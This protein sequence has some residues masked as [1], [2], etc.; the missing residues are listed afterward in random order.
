MFL[1][2]LELE[3]VRSIEHLDLSFDGESETRQWTLVLGENGTGKST[4]LK[5]IAL[6]LAGSDSLSEL[7][8]NTDDWIRR[9]T[10]SARI[11]VELET[12]DGDERA[13]ELVLHRGA[14][15][16][17]V[18]DENRETLA[19]LDA[20][21][22]QPS[23]RNYY[24][25]GYGVT[26]RQAS[27][28]G[29]SQTRS[30]YSSPRSRAVATLFSPDTN[31][32]DLEGW[33]MDLDYRRDGGFEIAQNALNDL[34]PGVTLV[35]IDRKR[36]ELMFETPDGILPYRLLSD[37][38]QNVASWVGDLLANLTETFGDYSEPLT[39]RAL[40]LIDEVDLHLHP[41][42]QR[43]LQ[44]FLTSNLPNFQFVCTTHSPLTAHQ[45]GE[46]ELYFLERRDRSLVRLRSYEGAANTLMLHQLI[47]S[48]LF[49]VETVDSE[50]VER[51]K[52]DYRRL[53]GQADRTPAEEIE[54]QNLQQTIEKLPDWSM[55]SAVTDEVAATLKRIE[56][57]VDG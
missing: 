30:A 20:A 21:I 23:Q 45:T 42:W 31:L 27:P 9:G 8:G 36:R 34:L 40:L 29:P 52:D 57:I 51:I 2:R 43:A 41:V 25:V 48:P 18:F 6:V 49:G 44:R 35:E 4:I 39:A 3:S 5:A 50:P 53:E 24:T 10:R 46:G 19:Q 14:S 26:R 47:A 55:H 11:R 1:R 56:Q 22:R 7:I 38:Y 16:L 17:E 33:A 37:G 13:A 54:L 28:S 12:A 15:A 32:V